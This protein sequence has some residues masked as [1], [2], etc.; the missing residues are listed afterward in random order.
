MRK[1]Q[2]LAR[3]GVIAAALLS[4]AVLCAC[5]GGGS[6]SAAMMAQAPAA[7]QQAQAQAVPVIEGQPHSL[8]VKEGQPWR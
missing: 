2:F 6:G 4:G 7:A 5:G 3:S 8:L 1:V